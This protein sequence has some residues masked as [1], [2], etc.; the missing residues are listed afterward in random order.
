MGALGRRNRR[1][2]TRTKDGD[3]RRRT[4]RTSLGWLLVVLLGARTPAAASAQVDIVGDWHGSLEVPGATL[5]VRGE[6][7]ASHRGWRCAGLA[8]RDAGAYRQYST[9]KQRRQGGCS[10]GRMQRDFHHGLLLGVEIVAAVV[11][12]EGEPG[13][14]TRS[15]GAGRQQHAQTADRDA[16]R[17][18]TRVTDH[19]VLPASASEAPLGSTRPDWLRLAGSL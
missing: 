14:A 2:L 10:A 6:S 13:G 5:A 9:E 8:R 12:G 7:R 15:A 17:R 3:V 18:W 11:A 16:E 4:P 1:W 19:S